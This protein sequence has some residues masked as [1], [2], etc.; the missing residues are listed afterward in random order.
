MAVPPDEFLIDRRAVSLDEVPFTA[1]RR[2][3]TASEL[4]ELY[5]KKKA[6]IDAIPSGDDGEYTLERLERF[7]QE[8]ETPFRDDTA[9]D[10]SMRELWITECYIR[11]DYDGDGIAELRLV[12][13]AGAG[14][15]LGPC[16]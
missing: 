5:P 16:P 6:E 4:K 2:K 7:H 10:P 8:D 13:V 1:H 9:V 11:T 3:T 14:N 12:T 15:V